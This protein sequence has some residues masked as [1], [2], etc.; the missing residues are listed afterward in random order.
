MNAY[1]KA[2]CIDRAIYESKEF[3]KTMNDIIF[4]LQRYMA[5]THKDDTDFRILDNLSMFFDSAVVELDC[6]K[7]LTEGI[8]QS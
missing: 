4:I 3:D 1:Q 5:I 8:W 2:A 6:L 7:Q